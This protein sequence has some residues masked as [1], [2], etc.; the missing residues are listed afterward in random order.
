MRCRDIRRG[1]HSSSLS[2][3]WKCGQAR[4]RLIICLISP[5]KF[6]GCWLLIVSK[7]RIDFEI[8]EFMQLFELGLV[9]LDVSEMPGI[10]S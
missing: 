8:L 4:L 1:V 5:I 6:C 7:H 2:V 9:V 3:N 10:S